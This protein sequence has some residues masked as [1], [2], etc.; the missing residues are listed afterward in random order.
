MGP[1]LARSLSLAIALHLS[2]SLPNKRKDR[3]RSTDRSTGRPTRLAR[4]RPAP[5]LH[6]A[7]SRTHRSDRDDQRPGGTSER[8]AVPIRAACSFGPSRPNIRSSFCSF[9]ELGSQTRFPSKERVRS[10]CF[11][12]FSGGPTVSS[13]GPTER[14]L[15]QR[16]TCQQVFI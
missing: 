1:N 4:S 11:S 7:P 16:Q 10:F 14:G 15:D 3:N 6:L 9:R 2:A 13:G 12:P 8:Q 5:T